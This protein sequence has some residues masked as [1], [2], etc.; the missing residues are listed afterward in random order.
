MKRIRCYVPK[1]HGHGHSEDCRY[2]YSL[3][4]APKVGRT[5]GERI[6]S[7][8][9]EGN[10]AGPSTR[11]M[12]PGHRRETLNAY[13]NEW[14][15]QQAYKLGKFSFPFCNA[16][17]SYHHAASFLAKKLFEGRKEYEVKRLFF[18]ELT[19]SMGPARL[20]EWEDLDITPKVIQGEVKSVY[21]GKQ[22]KSTC[23]FGQPLVLRLTSYSSYD[24]CN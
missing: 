10:L 13:Y 22:T 19:K 15:Y 16:P 21:R 4:F 7:G 17:I 3:D 18:E 1:L 9:A 11:E 2:Q 6:E 8:W 24:G 5:H 12:N 14:N 23:L 20:D